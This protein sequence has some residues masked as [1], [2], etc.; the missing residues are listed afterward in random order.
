MNAM[1]LNIVDWNRS[2]KAEIADVPSSTTVGE[3]LQEIREAMHLGRETLY[4]LIYGG[5]KLNRTS[6][7]EEAGLQDGEEVTVAPEV[8]AG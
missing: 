6:S 8:S 2:R 5:A 7:L 3:L 1:S 4:H